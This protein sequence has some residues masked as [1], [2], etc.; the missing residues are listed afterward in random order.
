LGDTDDLDLDFDNLGDLPDTGSPDAGDGSGAPPADPAGASGANESKRIND[1]MSNWQREK[2][3]A[4]RL[5]AEAQG[6]KTAQAK[7]K[8][9]EMP[10]AVRQWVTAAKD[11]A[12]DRYFN[13]D[14]RLAEYGI[15]LSA[16]D[17]ETPDEMAASAKRYRTLIDAIESKARDKVLSEHGISA[18]LAGGSRSVDL[19]IGAMDEK[20][21]AELVAGVKNPRF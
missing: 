7:P 10:E 21:F 2:A 3:R 1:L 12:R 9:G 19:D 13:T 6:K 11:A 20:A 4:D 14:P 17:G 15:E 8:A 16:I 18:E 5:E